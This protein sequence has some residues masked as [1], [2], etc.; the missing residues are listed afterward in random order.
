[1][2]YIKGFFSDGLAV[3]LVAIG[4]LLA[5]IWEAC[6]YIWQQS[7]PEG[8]KA[9]KQHAASIEHFPMGYMTFII[10]IVG[11]IGCAA[12]IAWSI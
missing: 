12:F 9:D 8:E 1:M 4:F 11:V 5:A 7:V 6:V 10:A 2:D 3:T